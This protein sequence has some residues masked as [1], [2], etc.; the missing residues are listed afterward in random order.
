[1]QGAQVK[2]FENLIQKG[3]VHQTK[4]ES[5]EYDKPSLLLFFDQVY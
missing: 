3:N 2:C 4:I 5:I 1:M